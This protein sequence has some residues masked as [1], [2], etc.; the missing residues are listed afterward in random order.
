MNQENL[1]DVSLDEPHTGNVEERDKAPD[2]VEKFLKSLRANV[3]GNVEQYDRMLEV[4]WRCYLGHEH[5][6]SSEVA[7]AWDVA[8]SLVVDYR[9]LIERE[10]RAMSFTEVEEAYQF[11]MALRERLRPLVPSSQPKSITSEAFSEVYKELKQ[12]FHDE[13]RGAFDF[14]DDETSDTVLL[15]ASGKPLILQSIVPRTLDPETEDDITLTIP[16]E[17]FDRLSARTREILAQASLAQERI[18]K[19]QEEIDLLKTETREIL[20]RLR[21]V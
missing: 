10:L 1:D 2:P 18:A 20:E 7:A 14:R 11:E 12:K 8:E 5:S 19:D 17:Q 13:V 21:A 16:Q 15:D 6:N 9:L 3:H 4:L